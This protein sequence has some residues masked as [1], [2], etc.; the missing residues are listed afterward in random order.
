[1]KKPFLAA[2]F[3]SCFAFALA[4]IALFLIYTSTA[5]E[6]QSLRGQQQHIHQL[7]DKA[8]LK[9]A[10]SPEDKSLVLDLEKLNMERVLLPL[11]WALEIEMVENGPISF[12]LNV[13]GSAEAR[14]EKLRNLILDQAGKTD[15]DGCPEEF[16]RLFRI[17]ASPTGFGGE[18][19]QN[20]RDFA[21]KYGGSDDFGLPDATQPE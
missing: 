19:L 20:L 8:R 12:I 10:Q 17:Y 6:V 14:K 21:E 18:S 1:M 7:I 3:M 16:K 11:P 2:L 5:E 9:L 4:A 13:F 15:L